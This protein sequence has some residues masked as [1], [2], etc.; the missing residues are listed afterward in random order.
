MA[1]CS[2]GHH[3]GRA[4]ETVGFEVGTHAGRALTDGGATETRRP[5]ARAFVHGP[6]GDHV[7]G[8]AGSHG[9]GSEQNR[10]DRPAPAAVGR[11]RVK[12]QF[13]DTQVCRDIDRVVII[14]GELGDTIDIARLESG[15]G[16]RVAYGFDR[17]AHFAPAR[18]F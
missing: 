4:E 9:H 7:I 2:Q 17:Q 18:I 14:H 16:N 1:A 3:L 10:A 6:E 13:R 8:H 11:F 12:T 5:T 15:V